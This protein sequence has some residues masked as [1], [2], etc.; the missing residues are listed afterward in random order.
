MY[1]PFFPFILLFINLYILLMNFVCPIK[2]APV[3]RYCLNRREFAKSTFPSRLFSLFSWFLII[4]STF[5]SLFNQLIEHVSLLSSWNVASSSYFHSNI[6]PVF[7]FHL[8]S[9]SVSVFAIFILDSETCIVIIC[10]VNTSY[11]MR[12]YDMPQRLLLLI[13]TIIVVSLA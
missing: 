9:R 7:F 6:F 10:V 11:D 1:S 3:C 5:S 4:V 13:L 8:P 2:I 12:S